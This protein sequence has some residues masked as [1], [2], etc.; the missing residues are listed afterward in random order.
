MCFE[1][2]RTVRHVRIL[3]VSA[4]LV[5]SAV[6]PV[7][8]RAAGFGQF[9]TAERQRLA[10]GESFSG[11][12]YVF[13][14]DTRIDGVLDG[15]LVA[16]TGNL[17][18]NGEVIGDT[19][20]G[21]W[22]YRLTGTA[23]DSVR[24]F[25]SSAIIGGVIEGDLVAFTGHLTVEEGARITGN[26]IACSGSVTIAGTVDGK[27]SLTGGEVE[28]DGTVGGDAHIEVDAVRL[29]PGA[30]ILGDLTYASRK[31]IEM[32]EGAMIAGETI[33]KEQ[34]KK[35]TRRGGGW[36]FFKIAWWC[37]ST[38]SAMLVGLVLVALFRR[39]FPPMT[40][41]IGGE[42][43]IGALIG[44]GAFLVVPAASLLAIVLIVSLPLGL[45]SLLLF[46]IALYLAQM[47]VAAWLGGRLLSLLGSAAPSPYLAIVLGLLVL[48]LV[49]LV[50]YLGTL[51]KLAAIWLGLG[52]MILATRS[53]IQQRSARLATP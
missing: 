50:P 17:E 34:P 49:F 48:H 29:G 38:L 7:T 22:Q 51:L 52:A 28:I 5:I 18:V 45:V 47:P 14:E 31:D 43:M 16:W 3:A 32:D 21:T 23:R 41:A 25:A 37:W 26:L 36:S 2:D 13:A 4:L 8:A 53:L 27:L 39:V 46:L 10:S 30:R 40:G 12:A 44:F 11:D 19:I 6:A 33:L 42:P 20:V 35:E 24:V 9:T 15:D 1:E